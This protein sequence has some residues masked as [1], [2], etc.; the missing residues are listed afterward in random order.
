VQLLLHTE[1]FWFYF[2]FV[3]KLTK[4]A[5]YAILLMSR[6]AGNSEVTQRSTS[7]LSRD[8]GISLPMVNKTVKL[9]SKSGLLVSQRGVQGGYS[10]SKPTQRINLAEIIAAVEGPIELTECTQAGGVCELAGQCPTKPNWS[11]I[12][13]AIRQSLESITL[14]E[15]I[16]PMFLR[17]R[18]RETETHHE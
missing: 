1:P 16:H 9:L 8:T 14:F 6:F 18:K 5:D 7:E 10:L 13:D 4:Q 3:I 15:M 12:S 11:L 17:A 2:N